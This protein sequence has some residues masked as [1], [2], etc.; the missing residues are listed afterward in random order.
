MRRALVRLTVFAAIV[1]AFVSG[2]TP[3]ARTEAVTLYVDPDISPASCDDYSAEARGCG[4]GR[5]TAYR[6]L[7]E[8]AAAA[9]PGTLV[10]IRG[11]TYREGL[12][13]A[14]SG[15]KDSPIVFRRHGT[16]T[17]IITG[18]DIG[19]RAVEREHVEVDGLTVTEVN[20]WARL[21]DSRDVTIR[22]STFLHVLARGTTG[23]I[24]LV[25]SSHNRILRNTIAEGNDNMVLVDAADRN[26]IEGN[27]F[28]SGRHSLL[29]VRCSSWNVF[30]G[31]TFAN[32]RQK[33]IEIYDCEGVGSD[34]PVRYD[35]TK[36][37][38]FE[39]N[40]VT[41]TR[42]S[43]R[44]HN[45][46]GI[47]HAAQHTIVRRNVFRHNAG[48]GVNYQEYDNEAR[49]VYGNRLY[50]NTFYANRC[51]AIIGNFRTS[52]YRDQQVKNNLLYKNVDCHNGGA[53]INIPDRRAVILTGNSVE[54]ADPGF[55]DA[56]GNDFRLAQGSRMIDIAGPLTT[57]MLAG[58]GTKMV[59]KDASYFYD[60]YS[61]ASET[62]DTIQLIGSKDSAV[63]EAIDY[64]TNTLTLDRALTWSKEQGVGLRYAG[65]APDMGAFEVGIDT[66]SERPP[67][68][69]KKQS[70]RLL[71][72]DSGR[73]WACSLRCLTQLTWRAR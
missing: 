26:L 68:G 19:I 13:L 35:S 5:A 46:N 10:S 6:T 69:I 53:Q 22:N 47:Q 65:L 73:L 38:L 45:Y 43:S 16:E 36:R 24:K 39:L 42:G 70:G 27:T 61:I 55:V 66:T 37:N 30:R 12:N 49:Y 54:K 25:R 72:G 44:D 60:G 52:R 58:S 8:A 18:V 56:A 4:S 59:V 51:H 2:V 31:N 29:S 11:G 63:V 64:S 41:L 67:S 50:H 1:V 48:G 17:P 21:V 9:G 7:S 28:A 34:N 57:T 71:G 15:T 40:E 62:G 33:A 20:G 32:A 3:G 14:H 23:S